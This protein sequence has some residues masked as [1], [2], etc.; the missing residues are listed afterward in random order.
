MVVEFAQFSF[1]LVIAQARVVLRYADNPLLQFSV[2]GRASSL[3]LLLIGP[4]AP[5]DFTMPADHGHRLEQPHAVFQSLARMTGFPFQPHG[6][7]RQRHLLPARN[8]RSSRLFSLDDPQLLAQQQDLQVFFALRQPG[9]RRHIQ[10]KF[11]DKQHDT[12]EHLALD[13][14]SSRHTKPR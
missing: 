8:L 10:H 5:H 2:N 11:P 12:K 4:F 9:D 13:F 1:Q 7:D 3:S 6:Y 14:R